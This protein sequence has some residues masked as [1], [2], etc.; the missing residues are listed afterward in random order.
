MCPLLQEDLGSCEEV[1]PKQGETGGRERQQ[2][3][4]RSG[5]DR[6]FEVLEAHPSGSKAPNI[7]MILIKY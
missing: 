5:L 7:K 4:E 6:E 1:Y 3:E 2:G